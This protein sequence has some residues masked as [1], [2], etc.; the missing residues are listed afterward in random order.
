MEIIG[1]IVVLGLIML[2]MTVK[3]VPEYNRLVVFT[4]G[5]CNKI[6]SGPGIVF[7]IP[8]VQ[9]ARWTDLRETVLEIPR[10]TCITKDNAPIDIDFLIY[11]KIVEPVFSVLHV[12]NWRVAS[13][14]IAM[15]TLRAVVG[16]ISLDDILAK[17]DQI[18]SVLRTKLDEQTE[19]WGVKVNSVE[20]REIT[21]PREVQEAMTKQMAAERNRRAVVTEAEGRKEAA[22][23][24]AEGQKQS[25]ILQ[26]EGDRQSRILRAEAEKQAR[27]LE[28]EGT[29]FA[30]AKIF[31]TAK[32]IDANTLSLQY[33][34]ALKSIGMS[35]STKFIFP[36]ELTNLISTFKDS[37][38][39][40][41]N[42]TK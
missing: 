13:Q 25:Q 8:F 17:R 9:S 22:I 32:G 10:Q 36:L 19:R 3:I 4:L 23:R 14:G 5:R 33:L 20:I 26:A 15:T 1:T 16:D 6:A 37:S 30:L 2:W 21:P 7:L 34:E 12:E 27:L 41:F 24:V 42:K 38:L 31:D 39:T 18:N 40:S 28:A 11:S 29:A 35:P